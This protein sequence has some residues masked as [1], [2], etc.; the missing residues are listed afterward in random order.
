MQ[1][2]F[3]SEVISRLKGIHT[4]IETSGYTSDEIFRQAMGTMDLI[5]MDWK[6]SDPVKHLHYT[7]VDQAPIRRHAEILAAGETP[8]ILRMPI[9]PG[10]NDT[11]EHFQ[12]AAEIVKDAKTLLRIDILPY[13]RAAGAKY[14]MVGKDYSPEFDEAVHP[15]YFLN[16]FDDAGIPY[17]VFR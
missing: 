9:I 8:F 7:G 3:V 17:K 12:T 5:M 1:W 15:R 16:V 4:A 13:Q 6:V 14:S 2:D 11:E 10:V